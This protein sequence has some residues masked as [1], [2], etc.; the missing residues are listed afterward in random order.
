MRAREYCT[1]IN[2]AALC[3]Y[4]AT[5]YKAE[6]MNRAERGDRSRS[7]LAPLFPTKL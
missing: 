4:E 7:G 1:E 6:M 5:I 3:H 2:L